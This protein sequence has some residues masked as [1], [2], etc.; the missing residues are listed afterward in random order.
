MCQQMCQI[1]NDSCRIQARQRALNDFEMYKIERE[2]EHRPV[3]RTVSSFENTD[4]CN[5]NCGCDANY[6]LC[7]TNCG[8]KI[9]ENKVC[10]AF[11]D[12]A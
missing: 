11:C 3:K 4:S 5:D 10:T 6:N 7:F 8:G 9:I 2:K 12:K 1:R